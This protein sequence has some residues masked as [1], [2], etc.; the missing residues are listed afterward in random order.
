MTLPATFLI[1]I[2]I[3]LLHDQLSDVLPGEAE[4]MRT[5]PYLML[6]PVPWFIARW[7]YARVYS[8][9]LRDGMISRRVLAAIRLPSFSV[10]M[11]Y[12]WIVFGGGYPT[13]VTEYL[14]DSQF[15]HHVAL[16]APLV[17][18]EFSVRIAERRIVR[19]AES[20]GTALNNVGPAS[21]P[22]TMFVLCPILVFSLLTDLAFQERRLEVFFAGTALGTSIGLTLVVIA[23]C[24]TLPLFFRVTLPTSRRFPPEIG[25]DVRQT[26]RALEFP[27]DRIL[28]LHTDHRV[29]N[30]AM[31]G[32]LPWPR[33]LV[34]SDGIVTLLDRASLRG[35]VAHE[36]GHARASHPALLLLVFVGIPVLLLH[37]LSVIDFES[38]HSLTLAIGAGLLA[39]V[40]ILALRRL[41]HQ[42]EFEADQQSAEA[43]GGAQ[44]CIDA[45]RRVGDL[46][47]GHRTKSSF[48]HPSELQRIEHLL[49]WER[50]PEYRRRQRRIS[51]LLRVAVFALFT[52]A[53]SLSAIVHIQLW[54]VDRGVYLL[55]SG[56][57]A[58]A[59]SHL[60]SIRPEPPAILE[61]DLEE[62]RAE[63]AA[64]LELVGPGGPG[65]WPELEPL[66]ATRAWRRG[67]E[68]F[69]REGAA[70]ARP[71]LALALSGD[72]STPVAR[73]LY[74]Y[75]SA[76][77]REDEAR[78]SRLREHLLTLDLPDL[79]RAKLTRDQ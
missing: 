67:V 63:A 15:L 34:L 70:A 66:L 2:A 52:A 57:F 38:V 71:W 49:N 16:L 55:Y 24:I 29:V 11:V 47:P 18:M 8:T 10:P 9:W 20:W 23:L 42:F 68:V 51:K 12:A 50:D 32:P 69:D 61:E 41:A 33:Y 3:V 79:V 6:V 30:A 64:A 56:E 14:P 40:T 58:S 62:L 17:A 22:M 78:A 77:A 73:S 53:L 60:R 21:L 1:G 5:L 31:V 7:T 25:A 65:M 43:L 59:D 72:H 76:I 37:P 39:L 26:A 46:H 13:V 4:P 54:N 75:S 27:E 36:I 19:W 74:L 45:L 48:R 35:V 28:T 44:P